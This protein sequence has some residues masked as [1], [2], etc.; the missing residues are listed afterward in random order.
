MCTASHFDT[1]GFPANPLRTGILM[2]KGKD[3]T[4][5]PPRF[6]ILKDTLTYFKKEKVL[7]CFW[8]LFG[9]FLAYFESIFLLIPF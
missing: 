7:T 1:A 4:R 3:N 6:L 2:K 8:P 5:W 9:L